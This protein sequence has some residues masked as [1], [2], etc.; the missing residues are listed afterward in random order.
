MLLMGNR[1]WQ[2]ARDA[3]I[4]AR[5]YAPGEWSYALRAM[6]NWRRMG[7]ELGLKPGE[8]PSETLSLSPPWWDS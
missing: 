4:Q 5:N 8:E 1:Q 7:D 6:M 3:F 2:E